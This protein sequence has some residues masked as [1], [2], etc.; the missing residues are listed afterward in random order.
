MLESEGTDCLW[1]LAITF[2]TAAGS[3]LTQSSCA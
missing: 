2:S 3:N 1:K